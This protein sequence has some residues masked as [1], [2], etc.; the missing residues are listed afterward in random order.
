MMSVIKFCNQS[1]KYKRNYLNEQGR[2]QVA[3]LKTQQRI[4]K[5]TPYVL[6]RMSYVVCRVF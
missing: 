6:R 2:T 1:S 4:N 5:L 3:G